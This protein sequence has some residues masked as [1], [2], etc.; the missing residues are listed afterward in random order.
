MRRNEKFLTAMAAAF[1]T[2]AAVSFSSMAAVD[3]DFH[4]FVVGTIINGV[5][6]SGMTTADAEAY[7]EGYFNGGYTL[8]IEDTEGVREAITDTSIGYT[9]DVTGDLEAIL[10]EENDGGRVSGPGVEHRYTVD[11]ELKYD[12]AALRALLENMA[13]V[14]NASPT[15]DAYITPYEE[16]KAFSIVPEVQGTEIDMDKLMAAVKDA[17]NSQTRLLKVENLDCYKTIQVTAD[18]ADLN[19]MCANLNR[20]KDINI[21]YVF[22]DQQEILPGLEAVKWIDGVSGSTVQVNQQKV[23]E[24]VKYLADKYDTYGKPHTFTSTSGRQ[25]SVNGDYG[26]QINQAEEAVALT[27]MVQNGT[28]QT[29]EPAYSRTAASRT[30]NDFGTTYVEVDMGL[31]HIYMYENGTLIAEAPIVT[32]NV[33]KGWTTPEGLYTLYYKERDR[34]LRGPK[35][36]DGTYSY[37]S[38]VSYWMP[39][40]GGIGLHDASWRG[41]FGGEIYKNNGSHGCINIPPKT[42]A[43]IYEHVYKGIPILCFY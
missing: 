23:A 2:T 36:A 11:A 31:Q 17:L 35:R 12:E 42:A 22:G 40:N 15:S 6:V 21:T 5:P 26:W 39:F 28:N 30:G 1:M 13:F 18:N 25:V 34:V 38:P 43:V 37:E 24:Y 16:G 3:T 20:Y 10:K 9:V 33:A 32:G 4:R 14:K 7:I 41:K 29:R 8:E 27:R 19:Q